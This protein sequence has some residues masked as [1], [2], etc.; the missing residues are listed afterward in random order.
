MVKTTWS[1]D[2]NHLIDACTSQ[3]GHLPNMVNLQNTWNNPKKWQWHRRT[4][5]SSWHHPTWNIFSLVV[6]THLTNISQIGSFPQ[7]GVKIKNLWNHYLVLYSNSE[8]W[9]L[10]PKHSRVQQLDCRGPS[11]EF[12]TPPESSSFQRVPRVR[13]HGIA[14]HPTS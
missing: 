1:R 13:F 6:S 12:L 9:V 4:S 14:P 8:T 5:H 10:L 11:R 7:I 2:P 3:M